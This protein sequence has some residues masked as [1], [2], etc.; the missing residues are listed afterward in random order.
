MRYIA[1]NNITC[2]EG[3]PNLIPLNNYVTLQLSAIPDA[4]HP[5]YNGLNGNIKT[6]LTT[7]LITEQQGLCCYCMQK[8]EIGKFHIEHL[9]PRCGFKNEE[10]HYYNLFL[11][12]GSPKE[13]KTHCG[14]AKGDTPIPKLISFY[15][16]SSGKK[17]EDFF[18]YNLQGEIL[19]K[20]G[21]EDIA[22][23]YNNYQNLNALTK[24]ILGVIEVLNLNSE[25]LKNS[26][27]NIAFSIMGLPDNIQQLQNTINKY[28]TPDASGYLNPFY[29]VAIYFLTFKI[30][31]IN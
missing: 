12:C 29:Y 15:N 13:K 30:S 18:K 3:N 11:S 23:N 20:E 8:L 4:L 27:K 26:R 1:K 19:P 22:T 14:Q 21:L 17:C 5:A 10:V 16:T 31:R 24:Q 7:Q 25:I 9:A 28:E 6:N 2:I